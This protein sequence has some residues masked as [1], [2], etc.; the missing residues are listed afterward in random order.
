M[1]PSWK[2]V[3]DFNKLKWSN[4]LEAE[5]QKGTSAISYLYPSLIFKDEVNPDGII[6]DGYTWYAAA[7]DAVAYYLDPRN[8]LTD[9][10]MFMFEK[11]SYDSSQDSAV[12]GIL[13]GSFM[14]DNF[15]ENGV[16][17]TYADAFIEA[18]RA[19]GVS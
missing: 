16:V 14:D 1:Y 12:S 6:I 5:S 11:L 7:K 4:A 13:K 15:T 10:H 18:G 17:K 8:F 9:R 3:A 2:F 19:T